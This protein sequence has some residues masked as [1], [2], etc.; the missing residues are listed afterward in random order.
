MKLTLEFTSCVKVSVTVFGYF[1]L[2]FCGYFHSLS[3]LFVT[4][5]VTCD[6]SAQQTPGSQ[7]SE[8]MRTS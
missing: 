8:K 3:L 4:H 1:G 7:Q 2:K 5:N 6:E